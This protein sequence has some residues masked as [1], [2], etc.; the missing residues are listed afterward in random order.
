MYNRNPAFVKYGYQTPNEGRCSIAPM[1]KEFGRNFRE[2]PLVSLEKDF[3]DNPILFHPSGKIGLILS[4]TFCSFISHKSYFM[5]EQSLR[6]PFKTHG[7][8]AYQ[9]SVTPDEGIVIQQ[10]ISGT[11]KLETILLTDIMDSIRKKEVR[12]KEID[13]LIGALKGVIETPTFR[14]SID[15]GRSARFQQAFYYNGIIQENRPNIN[16]FPEYFRGDGVLFNREIRNSY[17][18]APRFIGGYIPG[19]TDGQKILLKTTLKDGNLILNNKYTNYDDVKLESLSFR[20]IICYLDDILFDSKNSEFLS[21]LNDLGG[22]NFYGE[23]PYLINRAQRYADWAITPEKVHEIQA[24]FGVDASLPSSQG[25]REVNYNLVIQMPKISKTRICETN[26][27]NLLMDPTQ[28]VEIP[29]HLEL[30]WYVLTHSEDKYLYDD[31]EFRTLVINTLT[32]LNDASLRA[33]RAQFKDSTLNWLSFKDFWNLALLSS[34]VN[35]FLPGASSDS[36]WLNPFRLD[37]N[38]KIRSGMDYLRD[39]LDY[40]NMDDEK[41]EKFLERLGEVLYK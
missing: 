27:G 30:F 1:M 35:E 39:L 37:E 21:G 18:P 32:A 24:L 23:N 19:L 4:G 31:E 7:R 36:D 10:I 3:Q 11:P 25:D 28:M 6:D 38:G 29:L 15:G 5:G 26:R 13:M 22:I 2:Y 33:G 20:E 17:F 40:Y 9:K 8:N 34:K 12:R 41:F 14:Y 16:A